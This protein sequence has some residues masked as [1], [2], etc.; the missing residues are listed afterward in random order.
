VILLHAKGAASG[1]ETEAR[2]A[3][4]GTYQDGKL[5]KT[6]DSSTWKRASARPACSYFFPSSSSTARNA[7]CGTSTWP[8]CFMRFLPAFCFSSSLRFLVTSPP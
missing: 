8:T 4:V 7:S 1:A 2:V 5:L 3:Q 6:R